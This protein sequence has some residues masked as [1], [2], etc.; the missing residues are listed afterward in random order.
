[1]LWHSQISEHKEYGGVVPEIAARSHINYIDV[2]VQNQSW[3][4]E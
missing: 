1:M 4:Q 3:E 2:V